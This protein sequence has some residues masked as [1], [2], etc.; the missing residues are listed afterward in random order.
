MN[1]RKA[2]PL[3]ALTLLAQDAHFYSQ[4][5]V[6]HF[7]NRVVFNKHPDNTLKLLGKA[8]S[9]EIMSKQSYEL[10]PSFQN[11]SLRVGLHDYMLSL[12]LC[13]TP[14]WFTDD[15]IK[16]FGDPCYILTQCGIYFSA[17][18]CGFFGTGT[19]TMMTAMNK[20]SY[21]NSDS[22]DS[23]T[24]PHPKSDTKSTLKVFNGTK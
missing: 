3:L 23:D 22:G 18:G 11:K 6:K 12:T 8:I 1:L 16:R 19:K 2:K 21:S 15:F 14:E 7:S 20:P 24:T 9:N 5:E 17:F 10:L 4:N 13:L